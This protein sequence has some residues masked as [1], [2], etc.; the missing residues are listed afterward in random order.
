MWTLCHDSLSSLLLKSK[1]FTEL[2]AGSRTIFAGENGNVFSFPPSQIFWVAYFLFSIFSS[3][4][5]SFFPHACQISFFPLLSLSNQ[6][7]LHTRVA[8]FLRVAIPQ[9]KHFI[10]DLLPLINYKIK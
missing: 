9:G 2:F 7:L 4:S 8:F 5:V 1:A 3:S 10:S 6:V